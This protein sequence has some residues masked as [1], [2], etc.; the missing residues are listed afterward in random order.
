[1]RHVARMAGVNIATLLYHFPS[2]DDLFA[3]VVSMMKG[4]ELAIVTAWRA[5][6]SDESLSRLDSLKET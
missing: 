6:V 4:G 3:E 5:M 2:K 1:M